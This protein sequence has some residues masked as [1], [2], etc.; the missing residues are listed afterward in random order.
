MGFQS[1]DFGVVA[2]ERHADMDWVGLPFRVQLR[3][4]GNDCH[5]PRYRTAGGACKAKISVMHGSMTPPFGIPGSHKEE[6]KQSLDLPT[7]PKLPLSLPHLFSFF[8]Y[9]HLCFILSDHA[10]IPSDFTPLRSSNLLRS[11][12]DMFKMMHSSLLKARRKLLL[13]ILGD[14]CLAARAVQRLPK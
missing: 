14:S 9:P 3:R 12:L 1:S 13:G 4:A 8:P 10:S 11:F 7:L 6:R 5:S 2:Y